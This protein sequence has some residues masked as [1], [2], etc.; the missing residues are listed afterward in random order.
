MLDR[1]YFLASLPPSLFTVL[2]LSAHCI[3]SS[4]AL[5][6][7]TLLLS[8]GS[9]PLLSL[10]HLTAWNSHSPG[11]PGLHF[12]E[13]CLNSAVSIKPSFTTSFCSPLS[14]AELSGT[15]CLFHLPLIPLPP[16][17]NF[18][19]PELPSEEITLLEG[20]HRV[21]DFLGPLGG[22]FGTCSIGC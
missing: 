16:C 15:Y 17:C 6:P 14:T 8:P 20:R 3:L 1:G 4:H 2:A 18:A 10:L 13:I 19:Y 9:S 12:C 21:P 22:H 7:E 11:L 5:L